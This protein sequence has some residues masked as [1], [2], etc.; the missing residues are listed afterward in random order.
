MPAALLDA[1]GGSRDHAERGPLAMTDH[2]DP[3]SILTHVPSHPE[4]PPQPSVPASHETDQTVASP[5]GTT[6]QHPIT[7]NLVRADLPETSDSVLWSVIRSASSG[8]DFGEYPSFVDAISGPSDAVAGVAT[9]DPRA[10]FMQAFRCLLEACACFYEQEEDPNATPDGFAVSK[11]L[12]DISQL[13]DQET[14]GEACRPIPAESC[15]FA[16]CARLVPK[17]ILLS[18]RVAATSGAQGAA[19]WARNWRAELHTYLHAMRLVIGTD[20]ARR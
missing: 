4:P 3:A 2:P 19:A 16:A 20:P 5:D 18:I 12:S 13:L 10:R 14:D 11:A 6:E 15:R 17:P 9:E 8:L 1:A 7:I